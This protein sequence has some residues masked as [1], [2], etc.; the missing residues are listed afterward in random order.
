MELPRQLHLTVARHGAAQDEENLSAPDED[1]RPLRL[2]SDLYNECQDLSTGDHPRLLGPSSSD[3][4]VTSP[5]ADSTVLGRPGQWIPS[6]DALIQN[7]SR[8]ARHDDGDVL[9]TS[10]R[11][12]GMYSSIWIRPSKVWLE[13]ISSAMSG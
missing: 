1:Q 4:G 2:C 12:V 9:G 11:S 13:I 10:S 7:P 5:S 8:S 3:S 6:D